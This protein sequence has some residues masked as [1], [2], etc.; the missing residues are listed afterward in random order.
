MN[1]N[2]CIATLVVAASLLVL[3]STAPG[4]LAAQ[5]EVVFTTLG[6]DVWPDYDRPGVLVIYRATIAPGVSLPTA[7]TLRIPAAA[8]APSAVAERQTDGKLVNV[9]FERRVAG[10]TAFI[11][12]T[13]SRPIL[14][15][16]YYDPAIE[17]DG[18]SHRYVFTW[19]GDYQVGD[20]SV[21]IQQPDLAQNLVTEPA[22]ARRAPG[23]DGLM[24]HTVGLGAVA[25]G[26]SVEVTVSY[27]KASDQLTVE[28][29]PEVESTAPPT[30][31]PATPASSVSDAEVRLIVMVILAVAAIAT[32]AVIVLR[33]RGTPT[34]A[35]TPGSTPQAGASGRRFC[36][37][38]GGGA[39]PGDRFCGNC[40]AALR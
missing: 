17:R 39:A 13:V 31:A 20:L 5:D 35:A 6:I 15:M 30:T 34:A 16:E 29:M 22:A 27:D 23:V 26:E 21:S 7:V 25:A 32:I 1:D 9:P 4:A 36:T 37:Q 19:P 12:M 33:R 14:Q 8:G 28:T 3:F 2:A 18:A 24:Y 11:E 40:G 38:C 10:D